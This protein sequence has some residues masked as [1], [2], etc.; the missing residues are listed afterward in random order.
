MGGKKYMQYLDFL[1]NFKLHYFKNMKCISYILACDTVLFTIFI[2]F[3]IRNHWQHSPIIGSVVQ[4]LECQTRRQT[5]TS[6]IHSQ[7]HK[8]PNIPWFLLLGKMGVAVE[9]SF[10]LLFLLL[11]LLFEKGHTFQ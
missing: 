1:I 4:W 11:L 5:I 9:L 6:N 3:E 10:L 8:V 2:K 7:H